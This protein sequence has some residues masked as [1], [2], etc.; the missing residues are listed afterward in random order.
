[1]RGGFASFVTAQKKPYRLEID[2]AEMDETDSC[3]IVNT[4]IAVKT[5]EN[6]V[7]ENL[8]CPG[9]PMP[10]HSITLKGDDVSVSGEYSIPLAA[11]K[12]ANGAEWWHG[13]DYDI[14]V[15]WQGVEKD[16]EYD[17]DVEVTS[18]FLTG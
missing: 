6:V 18:D 15:D 14:L 7:M 8:K 16:A 17:I 11:I 10:Q 1:M 9:K 3:P 13:M 5:L 2:Y 4:R 12:K